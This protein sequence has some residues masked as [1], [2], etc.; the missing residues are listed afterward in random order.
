MIGDAARNQLVQEWKARETLQ[1]FRLRRRQ[2]PSRC[3][4]HRA[5]RPRF[6]RQ[7]LRWPSGY[8]C[9]KPGERPGSQRSDVKAIG[10]IGKD[11]A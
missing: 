10:F 5:M 8:L 1:G 11:I 4:S 7:M 9:L 2:H 3:G 6:G